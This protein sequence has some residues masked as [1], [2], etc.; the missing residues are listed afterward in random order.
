MHDRCPLMVMS[1][2]F[3]SAI[4][5]IIKKANQGKIMVSGFFVKFFGKTDIFFILQKDIRLKKSI[6]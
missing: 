1:A 5:P 3:I 2:P 4:L 6:F